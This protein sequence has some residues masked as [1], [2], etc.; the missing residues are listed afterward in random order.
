MDLVR[1][2]VRA[3]STVEYRP[4]QPAID[5]ATAWC[6]A[7][8][9]WET[10]IVDGLQ[11]VRPGGKVVTSAQ[12]PPLPPFATGTD[13]GLSIFYRPLI[14]AGVVAIVI[15]LAGALAMRSFQ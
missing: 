7:G 10:V 3:D 6:K 13:Y 14:F 1:Y 12:P 5:A 11:R 15:V 9:R 2:V 8:G 4:V